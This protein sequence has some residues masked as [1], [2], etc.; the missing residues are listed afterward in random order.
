MPGKMDIKGAGIGAPRYLLYWFNIAP[1]SGSGGI[2]PNPRKLI[3]EDN[4]IAAGKVI[5]TITINGDIE[6]GNT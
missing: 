1:Q 6:L 2:I 5:V 4:K 3:D